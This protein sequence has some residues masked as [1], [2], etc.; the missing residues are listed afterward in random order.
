MSEA[1]PDTEVWFCPNGEWV[2]IYNEPFRPCGALCGE[3]TYGA[4]PQW[5]KAELMAHHRDEVVEGNEDE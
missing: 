4:L 2:T 3:T 5:A 1:S